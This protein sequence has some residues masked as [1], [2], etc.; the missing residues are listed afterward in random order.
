MRKSEFEGLLPFLAVVETGSFRAAAKALGLTPSAVSQSVSNLEARLGVPLLSRTTRSIGLTQ[1][2]E[3]MLQRCRPA[4][5]E[6]ADAFEG[7]REFG[8]RPSGLLR[9]NA[10]RIAKTVVLDR[11]LAGFLDTYPEIEVEVF[12][13]DG[14]ADIVSDGFDAGLRLG[15]LVEPDMISRALTPASQMAVVASPDY[16]KRAGAPKTPDDL[17]DHQCIN[18]RRPTRR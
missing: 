16:L 11:V 15:Q 1:A 18:F 6:I 12:Y 13:D 5:S 7:V 3:V 17:K 14:I 2:G 4:M 10:P 9:L 8:E